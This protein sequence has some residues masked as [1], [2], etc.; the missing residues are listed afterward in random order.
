MRFTPTL[1]SWY[2]KHVR[3]DA[4]TTVA[5]YLHHGWRVVAPTLLALLVACGSAGLHATPPTRPTT[6]PPPT[7]GASPSPS[8]IASSSPSPTT[9]PDPGLLPQTHVLPGAAGPFFDAGAQALWRGIVTDDVDAAMPFFF[10]LSAYLQVKAIA[11]PA[12]DWHSRLITAYARDIHALHVALGPA[13]ATAQLGGLDVPERAAVWVLPG[14]EH[15][16]IGYFRVYGS[17]LRYT[18][19]GRPGAFTVTS[20][21]SWRGQWYVVHL[22]PVS[23]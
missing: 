14:Q 6:P 15:N 8:S 10:P 16:R 20:L 17:R 22:G 3:L 21:I 13:A 18:V 9:S 4:R 1:P 19:A 12:H 7:T 23:S 11:D 5:G 2:D